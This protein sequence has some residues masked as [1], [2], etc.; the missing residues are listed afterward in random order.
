[1]YKMTLKTLLILALVIVFNNLNA[2][3]S[4]SNVEEL[5]KIQNGTTYIA[6]K[7]PDA[8]KS[9]PYKEVFEKYWTYSDIQFIKY[10]EVEDLLAPGAA[11]FTIG[12]YE[13]NVQFVRL[14]ESGLRQNGIDYTVTHIYLELWTCN[15]AYF[16]K[17]KKKKKRQ[18]EPDLKTQVARVELF[19]DFPTL[20]KPDNL[21]QTDYDADGHIRNWGPGILKNYLQNLMGLLEKG[22]EKW[23]YAKVNNDRALRQLNRKT[24][25]VPDYVLTKFNKFTGDESQKHEEDDLFKKIDLKYKIIPTGEL[26]EKILKEEEPFYYLIYIKSSTDKYVSIINSQTGEMIYSVYSPASYN[27]KQKDFK[28]LVK[29]IQKK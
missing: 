6:M 27:I 23:L 26:N 25:Y 9:K 18:S 17:T 19:T 28:S 13:T 22:E 8:E 11:F 3:F 4:I 24:L 1:M 12:G 29:E 20:M 21:Y 7:D 2:Q 14:Y 15:D 16:D 10:E 5:A